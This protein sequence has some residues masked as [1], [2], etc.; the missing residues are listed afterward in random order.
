[1][2]PTLVGVMLITFLLVRVSGDPARFVLGEMVSDEAI[3]AF[4]AEHGLDRP[5]LVQFITFLREILHGD[6]GT[7]LRHREPVLKLFLE[8]IPATLQ[9]G[10]AAYFVG[11]V[12]GV[13]AGILAAIQAGSLG[14]R[15]IRFLV[16]IG[17]SIPVFYLGLLLI[18]LVS[19]QLGWLPTGGRGGLRYL[20]LPTLALSS[21]LIALV[22]RFTRSVMLDVLHQ[23]YVRT[24]RSKGL[25]EAVVV[26]KHAARNAAIS[27]VTLLGLE[28][29]HIISGAA[30]TETVFSWP[31][32]GRFVIT[33]ISTRD[34]P[35]VQG[36][37]LILT[38]IVVVLNL[39]IDI[40]YAYLDPRIKY[41]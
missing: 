34:Y 33:A 37:V 15:A 19:L 6:F 2:I 14:D 20:I 29:G 7:S 24:A 39:A 17:Q 38:A 22:A 18:I 27:L 1:M 31:G 21:R 16:L 8:R 25:S 11:V 40:S 36:T 12:V 23:D 10:L 28:F 5:I 35:V 32:V 13:T 4:R 41:S 26:W 3:A 30:V 9:L